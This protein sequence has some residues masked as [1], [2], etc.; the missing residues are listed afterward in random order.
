ML[1][2]WTKQG[3][4]VWFNQRF[5][6]LVAPHLLKGMFC[7]F[8][9]NF[10]VVVHVWFALV[11]FSKQKKTATRVKVF[12]RTNISKQKSCARNAHLPVSS[13]T[14]TMEHRLIIFKPVLIQGAN[15]T[16]S[17]TWSNSTNSTTH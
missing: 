15:P 5:E 4:E 14:Y 13:T 1:V 16:H 2:Y 3:V 8:S 6:I 17:I 12:K 11:C 7:N 10:R 9:T